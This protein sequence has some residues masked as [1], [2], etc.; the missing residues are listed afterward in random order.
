MPLVSDAKKVQEW[1]NGAPEKAPLMSIQIQLLAQ[2]REDPSISY[3]ALAKKMG[4]NRT[5]VMRNIQKLK[6]IGALKRISSKKT[7][8]GR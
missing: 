2:I 8:T 5:T 1:R 7:D 6:N 4:R 3:D